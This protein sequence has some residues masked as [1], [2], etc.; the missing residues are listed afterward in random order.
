MRLGLGS[1]PL[2]VDVPMGVRARWSVGAAPRAVGT[3]RGPGVAGGDIV[4]TTRTP[5]HNP[6]GAVM[7]LVWLSLSR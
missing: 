1:A 7:G 2:P 6:A 3:G 4:M 5:L